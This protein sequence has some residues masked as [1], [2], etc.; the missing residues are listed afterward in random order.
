[1]ILKI[2]PDEQEGIK[3]PD[4]C[5]TVPN[6]TRTWQ[7]GC[8][9]LTL[10]KFLGVRNVGLR[11]LFHLAWLGDRI[12]REQAPEVAFFSSTMFT[13]MVLGRYWQARH[14]LPYVLDFQDPWAA[15]SKR[16]LG[17]TAALKRRVGTMMAAC[18]EPIVVRGASHF[19]T[20]SHAYTRALQGAYQC[21][22]DSSFTVLPFGAAEHDYE[23][24]K[25]H[26]V[27]QTI[28]NPKD[29]MRHWTYVGR[30]GADMAFSVNAILKAVADWLRTKPGERNQLRIHFVGTDYAPGNQARKTIEPIAAEVGLLDVVKEQTERV[31]YF[32]ALQCLLDS[33]A[34]LVPGSDD[35]G[36]TASKVYP[37]VLARKPLL[38]VFRRESSVVKFIESTRAGQVVTFTEGDTCHE[39]ARRITGTGWLGTPPATPQTDWSEFA[40]YTARE[41]ARKLSNTFLNASR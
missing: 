8:L 39:V 20:V 28:F 2:D 11:S 12:I 33:Q 9:P 30:G 6:D 4:L 27:P 10:T 26:P 41:M 21:L 3:D 32:E 16:P 15:G 23:I 25:K 19:V 34:L 29:G 37:Y 5:R 17:E 35:P 24:L 40:P 13:V 14:G 38:A 18:L 22:A 7:A 36:Y 31:P 1:L